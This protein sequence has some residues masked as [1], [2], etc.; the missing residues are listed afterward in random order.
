MCSQVAAEVIQRTALWRRSDVRPPASSTSFVHQ[1]QHYF[2]VRSP[3]HSRPRSHNPYHPTHRVPSHH[4]AQS[5]HNQPPGSPPPAAPASRDGFRP[6]P[7]PPIPQAAPPLSYWTVA[8]NC[9]RRLQT[10]CLAS[11]HLTI[12]GGGFTRTRPPGRP[13]HTSAITLHGLPLSDRDR[14]SVS[15]GS[16][17]ATDFSLF[18]TAANRQ[19]TFAQTS[20]DLIK[21]CANL[22]TRPSKCVWHMGTDQPSLLTR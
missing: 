15:L 12:P 18:A 11:M 10:S 14:G 6:M 22:L 7:H 2:R 5:Y 8:L 4:S 19:P 9:S 16:A 3:A 1:L 20:R 21:P 17:F 13:P